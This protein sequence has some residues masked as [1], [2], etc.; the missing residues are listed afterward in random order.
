MATTLVSGKIQGRLANIT[1]RISR[2]VEARL[3]EVQREAQTRLNREAAERARSAREQR[4]EE[5]RRAQWLAKRMPLA[6]IG[7]ARILAVAKS[8][9]VQK[10]ISDL[11]RIQSFS[12]VV[13]FYEAHRLSG[14]AFELLDEE[15][16]FDPG[17]RDVEFLFYSD[18]MRVF[19][20][21]LAAG[22]GVT[23]KILYNP[24]T[25]SGAVLMTDPP[26]REEE[27]TVED[28]LGQIASPY[29]SD[30]SLVRHSLQR[31][32]E[33][34]PSDIAFQLLVSCARPARLNNYL[35]ELRPAVPV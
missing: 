26:S 30:M 20:G 3:A 27:E 7:L 25:P 10:I 22:D 6:R 28:F 33:W 4:E 9:P 12:G 8:E 15:I 1:T 31:R 29:P 2:Q 35:K 34:D 19:C 13:L 23:W 18:Y 21:S 5:N 16:D 32:W 24:S 17:T 11:K 14:K